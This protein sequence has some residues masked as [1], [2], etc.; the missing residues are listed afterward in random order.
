MEIGLY[1]GSS[2]PNSRAAMNQPLPSPLGKCRQRQTGHMEISALK[3]N[4][5]SKL[6]TNKIYFC[7]GLV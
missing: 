5:I 2:A 1:V 6:M 4:I 3:S 7:S